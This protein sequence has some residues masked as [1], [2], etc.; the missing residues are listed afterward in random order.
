[1]VN[2]WVTYNAATNNLNVYCTNDQNRNPF[3][4]KGFSLD[5][6]IDLRKVL[7]EWVTIGFSVATRLYTERHV[8]HSKEFMTNL[9]YNGRRNKSKENS[10]KKKFLIEVVALSSFILMLAVATYWLLP[11]VLRKYK[12]SYNFHVILSIN[13]DL[14]RLA[15]PKRFAYKDLVAATYGFAND[16]RLGQ[17][18]SGKVYKGLIQDLGCTIAVKRI[19]V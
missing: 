3:I 9:D 17:R 1:M 11:V 8:I 4:I 15:L 10:R 18:G 16:I 6:H 13:T 19:F 5:H 7:P 2:T 14:E 12:N